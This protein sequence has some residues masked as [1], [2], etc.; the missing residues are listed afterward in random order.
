[1]RN[2]GWTKV[3]AACFALALPGCETLS[4]SQSQETVPLSDVIQQIKYELAEYD[5]YALAHASDPAMNNICS[6]KIDLTISS[7][8][9]TVN[10][11]SD[12]TDEA[13]GSASIPIGAISAGPSGTLTGEKKSS[14]TLTF[15]VFPADADKDHLA[16]QPKTF[17]GKPITIELENLRESLLKS[18]AYSPCITMTNPDPKKD[19]DNSDAMAFTVTKTGKVGGTLKFLVFSVGATSTQQR[20]YANTIT[21]NFNGHGQ[22]LV[23]ST[24]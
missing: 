13:T 10:T 18:S 11:V 17:E 12:N 5:K 15:T 22:A 1:M 6:G 7:V 8:K 16:P 9:V 23:S 24:Q 2:L 3:A 14:Q 21:V 20:Q 19:Q 4:Q